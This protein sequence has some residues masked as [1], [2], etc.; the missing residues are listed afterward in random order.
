MTDPK[1]W[2]DEPPFAGSLAEQMILAGKRIELPPEILERSFAEFSAQIASVAAASAAQASLASSTTS[3]GG[4]VTAGTSAT[5]AGAAAATT[6]GLST[7]VLAKSFVVGALLGVGVSSAVPAARYLARPAALVKLEAPA[8]PAEAPASR[9]LEPRPAP[10]ELAPNAPAV[11]A[12]RPPA[13]APLTPTPL[14]GSGTTPVPNP[15]PLRSSAPGLPS[16]HSSAVA[17]TPSSDAP[18]RPANA[19]DANRLKLEALELARAKNLLESGDPHGALGVLQASRARFVNGAM[20]EE[21]DALAIEALA[22]QGQRARASAAARRFLDAF[23]NSPL[24]PRVR[25]WSAPE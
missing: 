23:P 11:L 5:G 18:A 24:A 22:Q 12:E 7:T 4:A 1:R 15:A 9:T 14:H 8:R 10:R 16:E 20:V 2:L 3:A 13:A 17:G 6:G 19:L 21:R 25:R